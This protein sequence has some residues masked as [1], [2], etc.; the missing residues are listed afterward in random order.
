MTKKEQAEFDKMKA[1][2]A[3]AKKAAKAAEKQLKAEEAA[4]IKAEAAAS[5][6]NAAKTTAEN[7]A[8]EAKKAAEAAKLEAEAAAAKATVETVEDAP[9]AAKEEVG[10]AIVKEIEIPNNKSNLPV[11]K[12]EI[13][14]NEMNLAHV[15]QEQIR[16]DPH[17]GDRLSK[18]F[19]QKY[20][21]QGWENAR[22]YLLTQGWT[23][24][25]I[26]LPEG[27][28]TEITPL[29]KVGKVQVRDSARPNK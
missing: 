21:R 2:A 22:K 8:A 13:P 18:G 23:L 5:E 1:E 29:K 27:W 12:H 26:Y 15:Y 7:E 4:K 14:A 9:E 20:D 17:G 3:E 25:I 19:A 24:K 16:F 11:F 6:A 10:E 28:P